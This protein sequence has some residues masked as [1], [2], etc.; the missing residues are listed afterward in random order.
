MLQGLSSANRRMSANRSTA[1]APTT[2]PFWEE[3]DDAGFEEYCAALLNLHPK[4]RCEHQ[5]KPVEQRITSAVRQLGGRCSQRGI[6][7]RAKTDRGEEWLFQCKRVQSFGEKEAHKVVSEAEAGF[8]KADHYV[9]VVTCGLS[10]PTLDVLKRPKWLNPWDSSRLTTEAQKIEPMENGMNL[11]RRFFNRDDWVKRLFKWGDQ[12]L[13]SWEE[14][15]KEELLPG[16]VFHHQSRIIAREQALTRLLAFAHEGAGRALI[17]SGAGGQGKSRLLLELARRVEGSSEHPI[18]VRFLSPARSG[19]LE[20]QADFLSRERELLLIVDDAH[21]LDVALAD[22][23]RAAARAKSI[24]LLVAT[25][26]HAVEAVKSQLFWNGYEA[27]LEDPIR[28]EPLSS[29]YM[30]ELAEEILGPQP[31]LHASW[32][33]GLADRCPLLVVVGGALLKSGIMGSSITDKEEFRERVFKGFRQDFLRL[34]PEGKQERI[35]RLIQVLSFV[36]SAAKGEGLYKL[37]ADIIGSS[38]LEVAEDLENLKAAGLAVENREGIRLY[39]DLFADAVLLDSCL[40]RSNQ[41]S[42]LYQTLLGKIS[43]SE[44]PAVMRNVAQ[45]DWEA[46]SRKEAPYSLFAPIWEQFL[47]SFRAGAWPDRGENLRNFIGR[48][49][50]SE[51]SAPKPDRSAMLAQWSSFSVFLPERTLELAKVAIETAQPSAMQD[52]DAQKAARSEICAALPPMLAPIISWHPEY[53]AE[54]LN[55][56]WSLDF[57]DTAPMSSNTANP[58][59]AIATAASFD[60]HKHPTAAVPVVAWLEQ[61]LSQS[62]AAERIRQTQWILAA[63]LKP[64]FERIIEHQWATSKALHVQPVRVPV[65]ATRPLRQRALAIAEEFLLSKEEVLATA[66]VPVLKEALS[67]IYGKFGENPSTADFE[68]WRPDRMDAL[69]VFKRALEVHQNST[70]LLLQLRKALLDRFAYDPDEQMKRACKE[71]IDSVPD[72]FDLRVARVLTSW[73]DE[74]IQVGPG[75]NLDAELEESEKQWDEFCRNIAQEAVTRFP[76]ARALCEFL[77]AKSRELG[78]SNTSFQGDAILAPVAALSASW[79]ASL[80]KELSTAEDGSLDRFIW[81]VLRRAVADAPIEYRQALD[82]IVVRGRS[83]QACALINFLG[84]KQTRG[85]GLK[86]SEREVL[87]RLAERPDEPVLWQLAS[88]L[89]FNFRQEPG[90]ALTV[91]SRLK[92]KEKR[93]TAALIEALDHLN[94]TKLDEKATVLVAKCFEN[95]G[96]R[97]LTDSISTPHLLH[98]LGQKFPKQLYEH[99]RNLVDHSASEGY[100]VR[101]LRHVIGDVS[102]GSISDAGY[103][104]GEIAEQWR[105]ALGGGPDEQARLSLTRTLLWSEPTAAEE[106]LKTLIEGCQ[107]SRE[108]RLVARLAAP[109]GTAFVFRLPNLVRLLLARGKELSVVDA[110]R[111][112]LYCSACEGSRSFT[113]GQLDPEYHY[114]SAQAQDLA[115]RYQDDAV[116]APFYRA[117]VESERLSL[118]QYQ[119]LM[120]EEETP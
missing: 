66:A 1:F 61:K 11:V 59:T 32:L 92:P 57:G 6:D 76:D 44:F 97:I 78:Q 95:A 25:R 17:F 13:L 40:D 118:K 94:A 58:I 65:A 106:R 68:A 74:E 14:F 91:L 112:T 100:A 102:F 113:E 79:C 28:L 50:K 116:L 85:G 26:S 52:S 39:P 103:L 10:A 115:N 16:R 35:D 27:R 36:S 33:A 23:A 69:K 101:R 111:E 98:N 105:K 93:S 80:L 43:L 49:F 82:Y 63:L 99:L 21:R 8:P 46:R 60:V 89:G 51:K 48:M 53:A 109:Q 47:T 62:E 96:E 83:E 119:D 20:D 64:F 104:A 114:I 30:A 29:E 12:P 72:S 4:V 9:L 7:I 73:S 55:L 86:E 90:W 34:Q 87:P 107:N 88:T 22:V 42:F 81:P 38:A 56:L 70:T 41:A 77:R 117:I 15:F 45:A 71:A 67:P 120:Q 2:L 3:L 37:A 75:P 110:I 108:L 5:G 84:W 18:R 19:L 31:S 24:R 54:A